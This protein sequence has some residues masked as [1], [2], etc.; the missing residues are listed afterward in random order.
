MNIKFDFMIHAF[1]V[2][3]LSSRVMHCLRFKLNES[4]VLKNDKDTN[5][6]N[7]NPASQHNNHN[8]NPASQHNN[9]NSNPA[10]QHNNHNSNPASQRNNHNTYCT[11]FTL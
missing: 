7:S 11:L 3:M 8:S 5:N 10:S 2:G 9:H 1:W 4:G 6:H